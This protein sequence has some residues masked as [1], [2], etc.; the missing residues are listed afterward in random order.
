MTIDNDMPTTDERLAVLRARA[1]KVEAA[2]IAATR[3]RIL[4]AAKRLGAV[5][6]DA[7]VADVMAQP[8]PMPN[9]AVIEPWAEPIDPADE[10][11]S[12]GEAFV[13]FN[14]DPSAQ[15]DLRRRA[16]NEEL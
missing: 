14:T 13:K 9:V 5:P 6:E 7:T 3:E 2:E 1:R 8:M 12:A 15:A 11:M 4:N 16:A 10:D